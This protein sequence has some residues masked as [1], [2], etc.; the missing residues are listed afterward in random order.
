MNFSYSSYKN[1]IESF[2]L[3]EYLQNLDPIL[4]NLFNDFIDNYKDIESEDFKKPIFSQ[5][6]KFKKIPNNFKNYKYMK[7]NRENDEF[8]NTW[9]F[10]NPTDESSKISILVKTYLNKISES[11]YKK[12]ST[13]FLNELLLINYPNLFEIISQEIINKCLFDNKYRNLYINL[14]FKIWSN[15]QIHYN[16]IDIDNKD[17]NYVWNCKIDKNI[18]SKLLFSSEINAKNDAYYKINFKKYFI[19]HIQKLYR[20]KDL[21]FDNLND[22]EI[23]LKK[24]KILLLVELIGILYLEKYINFDIINIIIIDLLHLNNNFKKIEDIEYEALYVLLKLIK[25]NK[26]SYTDLLEYKNIFND[27]IN[28]INQILTSDLNISKRYIFFLN[29][30]ITILDFFASNNKQNIKINCK[31]TITNTA[32]N[33]LT[34][35]TIN[36]SINIS[37]NTATNTSTNN[38]IIDLFKNNTNSIDSIINIYKTIDLNN[39]CKIIHDSIELFIDQRNINMLIINFF[40]EIKEYELIYSIL[41]NIIKN[42]DDIRLDVPDINK[43]IIFI[44]ENLEDKSNK[45]IDIIN[46]LNNSENTNFIRDS[47][48]SDDSS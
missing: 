29:D 4:N 31:K 19:D 33:T 21:S 5:T 8:K 16:L 14:C 1:D 7:I 13:D 42:I 15:K 40:N 11:T 17:N 38:N 43:K 12:I 28:I 3:E 22:D 2:D 46:N 26:N 25:D 37:I 35:T 6:S 39:H 24:K 41:E 30:V 23:Y 36:T 27:F 18:K 44:I 34:N 9:V 20:S 47:F 10:K 32:I 48:S 45:K